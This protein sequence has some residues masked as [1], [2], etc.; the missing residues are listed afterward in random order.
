MFIRKPLSK[1]NILEKVTEYDIFS[2]YCFPFKKLGVKFC[3]ELRED[4]FPTCVIIYKDSRY[5]YKDFAC[6]D[7]KDCFGYIME[8][9]NLTFFQSLQRINQDFNLNLI[10]GAT[11]ETFTH[12][13]IITNYVPTSNTVIPA[14]IKV[15]ARQ[16]DLQDKVYWNHK[17]G[18]SSTILTYFRV[19]PLKGYY[20]NGS[21]YQ[22]NH[23]TYGYYFGKYSDGREIWKIYSPLAPK[24]NKWIGNLNTSVLMGY[25]Q[26]PNEGDI[27]I[28]TKSLKDIIALNMIN[29]PACSPPAETIMISSIRIEDLKN[30][31][32]E[33][34]VLYDNDTA[35]IGASLKMQEKYELD[36]FTMPEGS[37]DPS[38]FL[39]L[40]GLEELKKY[41]YDKLQ[42]SDSRVG[43]QLFSS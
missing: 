36:T 40:Y 26:L 1:A 32:K 24:E 7:S 23:L 8:K 12:K 30:R 20:L 34:K 31:F 6:D 18:Y 19:Y 37:K 27:L 16:W 39:E 21:Y 11:L 41:I 4:K 43:E 14:D 13:P 29:I 9:Y 38:D 2:Y 25:N 17:Y 33:I 42:C 35:G 28:I 5:L 3:S 22:C 15:V 10:S